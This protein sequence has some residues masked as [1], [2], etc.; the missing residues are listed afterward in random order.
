[1]PATIPNT[2]SLGISGASLVE[3]RSTGQTSLSLAYD[4]NLNTLKG[5]L[6]VVEKGIPD[7]TNC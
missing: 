3:L 2:T 6:S 7:S 4:A 1:M 5:Q